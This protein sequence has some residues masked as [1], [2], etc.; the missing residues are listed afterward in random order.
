LAKFTKCTT[1]DG[2]HIQINLDHVAMIRP[3]HGNRGS[4]GNE[5]IFSGGSPSSI[6]VEEDQ[7]QL[8]GS[9]QVQQG[10]DEV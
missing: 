4:V 8:L 3:H 6:F 9:Q 10:H 7:E 5:V 2:I 1:K